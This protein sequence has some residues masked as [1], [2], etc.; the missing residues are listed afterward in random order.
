[1]AVSSTL[2][3]KVHPFKRTKRNNATKG[4]QKSVKLLVSKVGLNHEFDGP[5]RSNIGTFLVKYGRE[6]PLPSVLH[7]EGMLPYLMTWQVMLEFASEN[8]VMH[9]VEEDVRRS[10]S[11]YCENC[12]LAGQ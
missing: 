1:M 11:V 2:F 7:R 9:V 3:V 6:V 8:V 10:R 4:M 12:R 5:F